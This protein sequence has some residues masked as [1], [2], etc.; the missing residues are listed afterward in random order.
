MTSYIEALEILL[1]NQPIGT[2]THLPGDKNIFTF[3]E[4]Y[5]AN[6]KRPTLSLSF[7]DIYGELVTPSK[8]T[9][10]RLSPFFSNLL[11]EGPLRDYLASHANVNGVSEYHLMRALGKDLPGALEARPLEQGSVNEKKTP[12]GDMPDE[13][14]MLQFSLAGVQLKFSASPKQEG[15]LTV[16]AH[17]VGGSWIIKLPSTQYPGVPENEFVMME[18][19]R[20]IGIDVPETALI[21]IENIQ[22][23]PK[24]ILRIG[25]YIYAIKR[26]DR[27]SHGEKIHIED[28]AQVFGIYSDDKYKAASYRNIAELIAAE[29]GD[30]GI[31]EFIRR[32]VFNALIGNGDM[33]LK[34]W[35]MIYPD[36]IKAVLA[37]AY[38]FVSTLPYIPNDNLALNFVDSKKFSSLTESQLKRFA[39]KSRLPENQVLEVAYNTVRKFKQVWKDVDEPHLKPEI[40]QIIDNHLLT[41][42]I[43]K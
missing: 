42:P 36:K 33:H 16:P 32:F 34:N 41:I 30:A 3:N 31:E 7:K 37:P 11:P 18:L 38:D 21:P 27:G 26:F 17:G 6:P 12:Y 19:A 43:Y 1:H 35:S 23:L 2:I 40:K 28:F 14:S 15:R 22:N 8:I 39:S 24:D 10:T 5:I 29:T 20:K 4:D 13:K 9:Q 25:K